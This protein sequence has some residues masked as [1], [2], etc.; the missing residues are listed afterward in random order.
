MFGF[1][2][3]RPTRRHRHRA[4]RLRTLDQCLRDRQDCWQPV[5]RDY[6]AR[7]EAPRRHHR[8]TQVAARDA[9]RLRQRPEF[10]YEPC[11]S[12]PGPASSRHPPERGGATPDPRSR[13]AA[14]T[15]APM[16]MAIM[17]RRNIFIVGLAGIEPAT[18]PLSGVRSNRL[19]YSPDRVVN[20]TRWWSAEPLQTVPVGVTAG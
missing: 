1:E 11:Q 6:V 14:A 19:S 18:S 5:Q 9:R 8:W 2:R 20:A 3:D 16:P 4:D 15:S 13:T 7:H 17:A 12:R 10:R